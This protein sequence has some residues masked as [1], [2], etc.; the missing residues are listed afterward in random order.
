M[1]QPPISPPPAVQTTGCQ[2]PHLPIAVV[3]GILQRV[4][5]QQR[6][7]D[8]AL[9]C[10]EW[11]D[12]AARATVH[13]QHLSVKPGDLPA[14]QVWLSQHAQHLTSLE[15]LPANQA[16]GGH[17]LLPGDKLPQLEGLSLQNLHLQLQQQQQLEAAKSEQDEALNSVSGTA[18]AATELGTCLVEN[19]ATA[20]ADVSASSSSGSSTT[21]MVQLLPKL[22]QLKLECCTVDNP[23]SLQQ[24]AQARGL[25]SLQLSKLMF[26]EIDRDPWGNV[27]AEATQRITAAMSA[28]LQQL[29]ELRLL[30]LQSMPLRSAAVQHITAAQ[31]LQDLSMALPYDDDLSNGPTVL[32]ASLTRLQANYSIFSAPLS[33]FPRFLASLPELSKLLVLDLDRC[34][35]DPSGLACASLLQQLRLVGCRLLP[36]FEDEQYDSAGTAALLAALPK[37]TRLKHLE[38]QLSSFD[39]SGQQPLEHY[40]GLTASAQ[41]TCLML[42]PQ[43]EAPLP[44]GAAQHMFPANRQL[45]LLKTLIISPDGDDY[46]EDHAQQ[47]CC[48]DAADLASIARCCQG[49]QEVCIAHAVVGGGADVTALLQLP[50]SCQS[51]RVGGVGFGD[52]AAAVLAQLTQLQSL[53]WGAPLLTDVGL[54]EL[55][56]LTGLQHLLVCNCESLSE[57][58]LDDSG[59]VYVELTHDEGQVRAE[60]SL[61]AA[62]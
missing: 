3:E 12:A 41:L 7:G 58:L 40:A 5:L 16:R 24:L 22:K 38:L 19:A 54:Q 39:V 57:E 36:C 31:N 14:L 20:A 43:Y 52:A 47:V 59:D 37:L 6:L 46:D 29:P 53:C 44:K 4:P 56:A 27:T 33:T 45:P 10:Q 34:T 21:T 17:V 28:L 50:A 51:L 49:L 8:C 2:V 13:I 48:L 60:H 30:E 26:L 42:H 23:D 32:P 18:S 1:C 61:Q 9:T 15:L 25:T 55:T 11:A 62:C 35:F